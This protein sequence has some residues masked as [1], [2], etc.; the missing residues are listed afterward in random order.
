QRSATVA[1]GQHAGALAVVDLAALQGRRGR[2]PHFDHR[3]LCLAQVTILKHAAAA[4]SYRHADFGA[5]ADDA[6]TQR[7][8][9]VL[10]DFNCG[11]PVAGE[12]AIFEHADGIAA[13]QR[14]R[15]LSPGQLA[16]AYRELAVLPRFEVGQGVLRKVSLV[17]GRLAAV[18]DAGARP[19]VLANFAL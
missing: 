13:E 14:P 7:G 12:R 1:N 10:G 15:L 9:R 17:D 16:P 2:L 5:V 18:V 6:A 4:I 3:Q 19:L 8:A 11:F